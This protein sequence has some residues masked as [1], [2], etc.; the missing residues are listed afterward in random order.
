MIKYEGRTDSRK[1]T[2]ADWKNT[3]MPLCMKIHPQ[4]FLKQRSLIE[5]IYNN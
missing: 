1:Y 4:I 3:F 5:E 2:V